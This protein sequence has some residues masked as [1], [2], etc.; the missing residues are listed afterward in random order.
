MR[1]IEISVETDHEA[2]EAVSSLL[3]EYGQRGAVVE[4]IWEE[5]ADTPVIRV[6]AY[7]SPEQSATLPRIEEAL[8]HLGQIYPIPAPSI[9]WLSGA[10]WLGAWKSGYTL[11]RIG[12]HIVVKPSWQGYAAAA[13]EIVIELD[14]GLAFGT[15]LHPTTRLCLEAAEE[16]VLQG[17]HVLDVG[18]GSGILAIAAAKLGAAHI[19]ALDT[20][21]MALQVAEENVARNGVASVISLKRASLQ[22]LVPQGHAADSDSPLGGDKEKGP[23]SLRLTTAAFDLLMM[24]ILAGVIIASAAAIAACLR[25]KG[26]FIVSGILQSQERSVS[27]AFAAQGL[28]ITRR[29]VQSDWV[30]LIGGKESSRAIADDR[31]TA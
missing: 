19:L 10:D 15:G 13:D 14:P 12:R 8:W 9:R 21:T 7:L 22:Q 3:H 23:D 2:A 11:Q 29:R 1:C 27:Q 16:R 18:T 6:K 17:D 24:N 25:A 28:Q 30:A 26:V 20:D 4:E 5:G 31:H